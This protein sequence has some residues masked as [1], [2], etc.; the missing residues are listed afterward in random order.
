[1]EARRDPPETLTLTP[2]P[3]GSWRDLSVDIM[4]Q[5]PSGH[6]LVVEVD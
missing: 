4:G 1:M 3:D 6:E 5:L 2:L